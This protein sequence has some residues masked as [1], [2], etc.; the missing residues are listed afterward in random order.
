MLIPLAI[1]LIDY[2]LFYLVVNLGEVE[3]YQIELHAY[4]L[5]FWLICPC[6]TYYF[7]KFFSKKINSYGYIYQVAGALLL[8]FLVCI[9]I[10][11]LV[12]FITQEGINL[13]IQEILLPALERFFKVGLISVGF[14]AGFF[15]FKKHTQLNEK[16]IEELRNKRRL[17]VAN[18]KNQIAPHFLFNNLNIISALIHQDK[19]LA[20]QYVE[21]FGNIYRYIVKHNEHTT[22][23]V[24]EEI[25]QVKDYFFL[26]K[27]RFN[28]IYQLSIS[29]ED[30]G[31][32][33]YLIPNTIQSLV[34]NA[35][36]HN[37]ADKDQN[38]TIE[39]EFTTS[40]V[41]VK[42]RK[43]S[44]KRRQQKSTKTGLKSLDKRYHLLLNE[45][46]EIRDTSDFFEVRVPLIKMA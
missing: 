37:D 13:T 26:L 8:N 46:I 39:V 33:Y 21:K 32:N 30:Y 24:N 19:D 45:Q 12:R 1:S 14:I 10:F 4:I 20:D 11:I 15:Y 43:L 44:K 29:N 6:V 25:R 16:M 35:I 36:K 28:N 2:F 42:N 18:L 31:D 40:H 23:P 27:Y 7:F 3:F 34:E 5:S 22:V 38:L 41:I 9:V 17:E